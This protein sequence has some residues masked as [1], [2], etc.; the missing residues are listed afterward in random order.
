M[1]SAVKSSLASCCSQ[2]LLV[3]RQQAYFEAAVWTIMTSQNSETDEKTLVSH[4]APSLL[5]LLHAS[6]HLLLMQLKQKARFI[7]EKVQVANEKRR[8]IFS[9]QPDCHGNDIAFNQ[10]N[11]SFL[12]V[13]F[14]FFHKKKILC[15]SDVIVRRAHICCWVEWNFSAAYIIDT[16]LQQLNLNFYW[17]IIKMHFHSNFKNFLNVNF[18]L[19]IS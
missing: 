2:V 16:N 9:W 5:R 15:Y 13:I 14:Q 11:R 17:K 4:V 3:C 19:N 12:Y 1:M 7:T 8:R 10:T 6:K 18:Y